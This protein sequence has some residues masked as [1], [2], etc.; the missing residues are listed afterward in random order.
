MHAYN[1]TYT[2]IL[3]YFSVQKYM[4]L[5]IGVESL[6]VTGVMVVFSCRLV[7]ELLLLIHSSSPPVVTWTVTMR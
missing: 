2:Y 5:T 3:L 4:Q 7:P 6:E 1:Y